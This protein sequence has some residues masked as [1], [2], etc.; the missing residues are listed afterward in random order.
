L[1]FSDKNSAFNQNLT[2]A[3]VTMIKHYMPIKFIKTEWGFWLQWVLV[4]IVGFLVSLY[5]VEVGESPDLRGIEGAIGGAAI[6]LAQ[7][8]VLRQ[9]FSKA[10]GWVLASIVSW[11]LIGGSGLG[12]LGWMA[13]T[14]MSIPLRM[15]YGAMNG[16]VVGTLF[17]V[18]Q[19]LVFNKQ[20]YK[21]WPW[22]LAN[23]LGW[24][25][26]LALGWALGAVLRGFTGLFLGE[27]VGLTLTWLVVA[28]ITGVALRHVAHSAAV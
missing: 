5:W 8:F 18:A 23:T 10:W 2:Y 25:I 17:G 22:I 15:L 26:G 4:T 7:W 9:Q 21:A 24:A 13:P 16:A 1:S 27:V 3:S 6:G 14:V 28:V 12:A 20:I 19:G 11:G